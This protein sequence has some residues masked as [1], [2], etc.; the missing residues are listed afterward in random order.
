MELV[1]LSTQALTKPHRRRIRG[2]ENCGRNTVSTANNQ[3]SQRCPCFPQQERWN[4]GSSTP[5]SAST[6][7][8]IRSAKSVTSTARRRYSSVTC[9]W[10]L[11]ARKKSFAATSR[12]A[13]T[14]SEPSSNPFACV[15][16][17]IAPTERPYSSSLREAMLTIA[18]ICRCASMR[19]LNSL[20]TPP[21]SKASPSMTEQF[22]QPFECEP[23]PPPKDSHQIPV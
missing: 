4:H 23:L 5:Q 2:R 20:M 19:L 6:K 11:L 10:L 3:E 1:P 7:S 21:D 12:I 15:Q 14:T 13:H 9:S 8:L 22:P 16:R 18:R 17:S